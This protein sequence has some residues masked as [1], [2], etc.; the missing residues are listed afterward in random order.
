MN[1]RIQNAGYN[2]QFREQVTK[3]ALNKYKSIIAKDKTGECPIYR[4]KNWQKEERQKKKQQNKTKWFKKGKTKY[5]SVIFVPATPYSKLQKNYKKVIDKHGLNIKVV[6]KAGKQV[7]NILQTSDP[8]K[9]NRCSDNDC[10]PCKN[11]DENKPTNCRKDGIIYDITCNLCN[12]KY[13]GE[14]SRNANTRGREHLNDYENKRDNSVMMRHTQT[15]HP[16]EANNTNY[17][18]TVT[19]IYAN[20]C[21]DRQ[22]SEAIQINKIPNT[23]RINTKIEYRHHRLPRA[24]LSWE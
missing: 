18:M 10:F 7:K 21:M 17:K 3:S 24:T 13:I 12:A 11:N 19:Q 6:E 1:R 20:K 9:D 16:N 8:F 15:H 5:K 2:Q 14:S 23:S 4:N 22:L